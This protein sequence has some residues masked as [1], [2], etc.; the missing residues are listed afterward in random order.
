MVT[1]KLRCHGRPLLTLALVSTITN[2]TIPGIKLCL[3]MRFP[4]KPILQFKVICAVRCM[5]FTS[6]E[7]NVC[8]RS[9]GTERIGMHIYLHRLLRNA[10]IFTWPEFTTYL[11]S[12]FP[13]YSEYH[14]CYLLENIGLACR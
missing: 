11:Q 14:A 8:S 1:M 5:H 7:C 12:T 2:V 6:S 13:S 10:H 9:L 3:L 4:I